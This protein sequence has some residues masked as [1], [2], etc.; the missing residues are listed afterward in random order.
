MCYLNKYFDR[1]TQKNKNAFQSLTKH[2]Q[3]K[4]D[5]VGLE[6]LKCMQR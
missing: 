5:E 1:N 2:L 3:I 4:L 6:I